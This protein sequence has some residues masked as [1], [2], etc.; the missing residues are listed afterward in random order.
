M[1]VCDFGA[2]SIDKEKGLPVVDEEKCTSCGAC[3]NICPRGL[4]EVRPLKDKRVFVACK[5]TQKGG[6]AKKNC[7]VACIGCSKCKRTCDIDEVVVENSLSYISPKI[8]ADKYGI[9]LVKCC[10]TKAIV[11]INLEENK[12]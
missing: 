11:G 2:L 5:N 10:P 6:V 3:V 7:K 1:S 12:E 9:D 4:F 8:D